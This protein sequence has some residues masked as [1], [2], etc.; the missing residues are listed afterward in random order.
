MA[1]QN[2]EQHLLHLKG[3]SCATCAVDIEQALHK[4]GYDSASVNFSTGQVI[5]HGDLE[6]AK[7]V[8]KRVEPE[9]GFIAAGE[10]EEEGDQI[11]RAHV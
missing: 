10:E 2:E 9:V 4:S 7:Q 6:R 8:I 11:G 5:L 1:E 3:L